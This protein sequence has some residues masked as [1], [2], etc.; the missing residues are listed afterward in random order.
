MEDSF[1]QEVNWV[2]NGGGTITATGL[3][4]S[5][6]TPGTFN[7]TATSVANPQSVGAAVVTVTGSGGGGEEGPCPGGCTFPGTFTFCNEGTCSAPTQGVVTAGTSRPR[8]TDGR[9]GAVSW[10]CGDA[11]VLA[12]ITYSGGSFSGTVVRTGSC[13]DFNTLVNVPIS[14]NLSAGALTFV[15]NIRS[16][17]TTLAFASTAAAASSRE[18]R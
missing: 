1:N 11:L 8:P 17:T 6:G 14:G 4:T 13:R 2:V 16:T 15:V 9:N 12:E 3:F 18:E 10:L 7:V 5:N